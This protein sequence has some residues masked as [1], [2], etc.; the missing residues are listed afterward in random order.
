MENDVESGQVCIAIRFDDDG[1]WEEGILSPGVGGKGFRG[2]EGKGKKLGLNCL[3]GA[4]LQRREQ[5]A[6][7]GTSTAALALS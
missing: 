7:K 1:Q 6:K 5:R 4:A 3:G 2:N